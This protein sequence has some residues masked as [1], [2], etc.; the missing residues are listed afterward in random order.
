MRRKL[1]F[2]F[3][4][5]VTLPCFSGEVFHAVAVAA[6]AARSSA[7]TQQQQIS[8]QRFRLLR[9]YPV[10][11]TPATKTKDSRQ[12]QI[13]AVAVYLYNMRRSLEVYQ[14]KD[15]ANLTLNFLGALDGFYRLN[16]FLPSDSGLAFYLA[17]QEEIQQ[18]VQRFFQE[19]H[20]SYT[21]N[22]KLEHSLMLLLNYIPRHN[23]QLGYFNPKYNKIAGTLSSQDI[24]RITP[25]WKAAKKEADKK[26]V[27]FEWKNVPMQAMD[28]PLLYAN[29]YIQRVYRWV[30]EECNYSS[31]ILGKTLATHITNHPDQWVHAR[32]YLLT[33]RPKEG[34]Y[35]L[36]AQGER[37]TL[38]NGKMADAWQYHTAVLLVFQSTSGTFVPVIMDSFL[39]REQYLT[40]QEWLDKFHAKTVFFVEPFQVKKEIEQNII[41]PSKV[42]GKNIFYQNH[43]YSPASIE[44]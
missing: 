23:N 8:N 27:L 10:S 12:K 22:E 9:Y 24:A 35:L 34:K 1:F 13:Y 16:E 15:C 19:S 21:R 32:I 41:I 31:Y 4:S 37:F 39:G 30:N 26:V 17:H 40:L 11:L 33:A 2:F 7:Q 20:T 38:S 36:P 44:K 14:Q 3:L 42:Q 43:R 28:S 18:Q 5:L 29:S 6:S 25:L